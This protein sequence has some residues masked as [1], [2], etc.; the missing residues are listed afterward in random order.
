MRHVAH[1]ALFV[2]VALTCCA[3]ASAEEIKDRARL[4]SPTARRQAEDQIRDLEQR[5]GKRILIETAR[6]GF[7]GRLFGRPQPR[8]MDPEA[9][10]RFLADEAD[11]RAQAAGPHSVYVFVYQDPLYVG[12]VVSPDAQLERVLPPTQRDDLRKELETRLKE[13]QADAALAELVHSLAARFESGLAVHTAAT[14]SF[15]WLPVAW[16]IAG[17][18][19]LWLVIEL[20][21][22]LSGGR[23][24]GGRAAISAVHFAGGSFLAG[25]FAYMARCDGPGAILREDCQTQP[26][27]PNPIAELSG[28]AHE[29]R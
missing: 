22:V 13:N 15:N 14:A 20:A 8:D 11:R 29:Q 1:G 7:L 16:T 23:P 4:F 12:L 18:L 25:L 9:R 5:Y 19:G 6:S 28:H 21:G 3:P 10:R 2:L 27:D 24:G 17:L 26:A